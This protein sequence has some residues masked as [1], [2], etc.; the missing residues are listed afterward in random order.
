MN[1]VS[2]RGNPGSR[3]GRAQAAIVMT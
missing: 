1:R 3:R 2:G